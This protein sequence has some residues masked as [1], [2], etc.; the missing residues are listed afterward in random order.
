MRAR[1]KPFILPKQQAFTIKKLAPKKEK[2][3]NQNVGN[4]QTNLN[5][6][7][8]LAERIELDQLNFDLI[9]KLQLVRLDLAK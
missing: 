9:C 7:K 8:L 4:V 2:K 3:R 5:L 6:A 1:S